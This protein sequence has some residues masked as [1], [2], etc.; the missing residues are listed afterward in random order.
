MTP[1]RSLATTALALMAG[2]I[3]VLVL[4]ATSLDAAIVIGLPP[5]VVCAV[6][7]EL[8]LA[9]IYRDQPIPRSR[10]FRML[11]AAQSGKLALGLW[12]G[13]LVVARAGDRTGWFS[14]PSPS[15]DVSGPISGLL[16]GVVV[17]IPISYAFEI[18]RVR[19]AASRTPTTAAEDEIDLD[20]EP[21]TTP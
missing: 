8:Y 15:T 14:I 1:K 21:E 16:V 6:L 10:F 3:A 11:V 2:L 5:L 17:A 4:P 9:R 18:W 19:R 7:A 13:Y 12:V 20:R